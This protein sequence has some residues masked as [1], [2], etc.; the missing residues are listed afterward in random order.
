M[1]DPVPG[2]VAIVLTEHAAA[3]YDPESAPLVQ[4][5]VCATQRAGEVTEASW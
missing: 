2:V 4:V 3:V 1:Q 5:R